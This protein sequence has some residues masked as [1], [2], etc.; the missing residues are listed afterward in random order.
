MF[1]VYDIATG[2]LWSTTRSAEQLASPETLA[3]AGR[4]IVEI[5][6]ASLPARWTWDASALLPVST[7]EVAGPLSKLDMMRRF[8]L[9]E[10]VSIRQS[11]DPVII[12]FRELLAMAEEILIEDADTVAGVN[13]LE[14]AGLIAAGRAAEILGA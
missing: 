13:Y 2:A 7:P 8:T 6:D 11:A 1:F 5:A 12:D 9:D 4:A 3:A 10:R 14:T